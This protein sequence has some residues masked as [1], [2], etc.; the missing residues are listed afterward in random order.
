MAASATATGAPG[1]NRTDDLLFTKQALLP[2]ELLEHE[3]GAWESNPPSRFWRP[4]RQPWNMAP[5]VLFI[6]S[7]YVIRSPIAPSK[8]RKGRGSLARPALGRCPRCDFGLGDPLRAGPGTPE[9]ARRDLGLKAL[10]IALGQ[11]HGGRGG[12]FDRRHLPSV[13]CLP[14]QHVATPSLRMCKR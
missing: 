14:G 12:L 5:Y 13:G 8:R 11:I 10:G 4:A 2:A 9:V 1:R 6:P 7:K 3:Q